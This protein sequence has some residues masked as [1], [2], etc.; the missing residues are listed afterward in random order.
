MT[1]ISC[2]AGSSIAYFFRIASKLQSAPSWLAPPLDVERNRLQLRG[3]VD[4]LVGWRK[5]ELCFVIDEPLDQP[6][7]GDPVDLG[8]GAGDPSH[9][10]SLR[11][12]EPMAADSLGQLQLP[13]PALACSNQPPARS[14][15]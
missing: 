12:Y 14:P 1:A 15:L 9:V 4:D 11:R 3:L 10:A 2:S 5:D 6:W 8:T 7:T 13:G